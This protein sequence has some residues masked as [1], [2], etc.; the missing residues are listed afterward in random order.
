MGSSPPRPSPAGGP[1]TL[2][3]TGG[4]GFIGCNFVRYWL[5]EHPGDTVVN[6]DLLTYAGDRRG[7]AAL[8]AAEPER[9]HF[10]HGDIGDRDLAVATMRRW[11]PAAV[12][13]FAAESHV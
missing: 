4:A 1:G 13:N 2:L 5:R 12:I 8:A 10:V 3:V 11:R 7:I 9:Y 6:Y